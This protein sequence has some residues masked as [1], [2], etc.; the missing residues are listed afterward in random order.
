MR[1]SRGVGGQGVRIPILK[2]HKNRV[3]SFQS[4]QAR[5]Q[6]WA[7]NRPP[8][9]RHLNG[10]SLGADD[11]NGVSLEADDSPLILACGYSLPS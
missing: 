6:C 4:D 1:G 5:T 9:K 3:S 2:N 11:L 10:I 8:A 7:I